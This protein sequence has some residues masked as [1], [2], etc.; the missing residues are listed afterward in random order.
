M[1][2]IMEST[3]SQACHW[4]EGYLIHVY[5]SYCV[6]M[7]VIPHPQV[8]PLL[9]AAPKHGVLDG[10]LDGVLGLS[11][12]HLHLHLHI[13]LLLLFPSHSPSPPSPPS[14]IFKLY[15]PPLPTLCL[16]STVP[17]KKGRF[18]ISRAPSPPSPD[19]PHFFDSP[20]S[21]TNRLSA[22]QE[23]P[24]YLLFVYT[25]SVYCLLLI[26]LNKGIISKKRKISTPP[27]QPR[28]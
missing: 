22:I 26:A 17:T 16:L 19:F 24:L 20:L 15:V 4:T 10:V 9:S 25:A 14:H 13:L 2:T 12:L 21:V 7:T 3:S 23:G 18:H 11:V 27:T 6:N 28:S 5:H 1:S 8:P